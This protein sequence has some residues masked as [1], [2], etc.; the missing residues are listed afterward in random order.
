MCTFEFCTVSYYYDYMYSKW[1]DPCVGHLVHTA[2]L[3]LTST[4][5]FFLLIVMLCFM[6][7]LYNVLQD[8]ITY[9][10]A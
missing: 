10:V 9:R 3:L 7:I 2:E 6:F 8:C 5:L 4:G 1:L